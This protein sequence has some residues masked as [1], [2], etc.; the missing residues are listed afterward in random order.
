MGTIMGTK[1]AYVYIY[2]PVYIYDF[3]K[4]TNSKHCGALSIFDDTSKKSKTN[5]NYVN[6]FSR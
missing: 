6:F 4:C 1:L 3:D 2:T 5:T